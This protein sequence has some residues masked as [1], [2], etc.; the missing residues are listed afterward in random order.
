MDQIRSEKQ[1]SEA[2]EEALKKL[3][4]EWQASFSG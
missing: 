1:L 2:I 3:L 4:S